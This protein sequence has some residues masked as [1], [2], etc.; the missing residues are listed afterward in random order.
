[1]ADAVSSAFSTFVPTV[2][3]SSTASTATVSES[4]FRCVSTPS[5]VVTSKRRSMRPSMPWVVTCV[6]PDLYFPLLTWLAPWATASDSVTCVVAQRTIVRTV[7]PS[8][9]TATVSS[10]ASPRLRS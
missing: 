6:V 1:M 5:R 4:S 7:A 9:P 8:S 2:V 3:T 10:S